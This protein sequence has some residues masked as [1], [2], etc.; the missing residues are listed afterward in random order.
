MSY[1]GDNKQPNTADQLR[2]R[3][4]DNWARITSAPLSNA[5]RLGPHWKIAWSRPEYGMFKTGRPGEWATVCIHGSVRRVRTGAE[6]EQAGRDRAT[7]C[8]L[9]KA[10]TS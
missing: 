1:R 10:V 7:W 5:M 9:C 8:D 2:L 6:A 4:S 3:L